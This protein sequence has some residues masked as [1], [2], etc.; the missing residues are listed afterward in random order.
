MITLDDTHYNIV[1]KLIYNQMTLEDLS[2]KE[3]YKEINKGFIK[4]VYETA[5]D[6]NSIYFREAKERVYNELGRRFA[7]KRDAIRWVNNYGFDCANEDITN[8]LASYIKLHDDY[9]KWVAN[10][11]QG[12]EPITYYKVYVNKQTLEK[13]VVPINLEIF[14][15]VYETVR[16]SQFEAYAW[17]SEIRSGMENLTLLEDLKSFCD[18]NRIFLLIL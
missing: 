17:L 6:E 1:T 15:T 2:E 7:L 5:Y 16:A 8:F 18:T 12:D 9:D 10:G 13:A 3:E 11:S 14:N 4:M